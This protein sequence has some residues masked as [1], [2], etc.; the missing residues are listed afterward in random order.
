MSV[1]N[2]DGTC[3]FTTIGGIFVLLKYAVYE[4]GLYRAPP[5]YEGEDGEGWTPSEAA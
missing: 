2:N 3:N 1:C 4:R 5:S